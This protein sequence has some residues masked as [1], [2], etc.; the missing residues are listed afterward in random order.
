MWGIELMP[1]EAKEAPIVLDHVFIGKCEDF[2]DGRPDKYFA[3]VYF[4][5]YRN[6]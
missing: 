1:E 6:I 5:M 2:I 3:A 4:L